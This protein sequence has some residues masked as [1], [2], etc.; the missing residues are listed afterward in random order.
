M[1]AI[2][3]LNTDEACSYMMLNQSALFSN[4]YQYVCEAHGT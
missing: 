3:K 2:A 1:D 4:K